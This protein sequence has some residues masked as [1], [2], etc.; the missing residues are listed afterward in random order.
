MNAFISKSYFV[1]WV[2]NGAE[3]CPLL[4]LTDVDLHRGRPHR[5]QLVG[6][7]AAVEAGVGGRDG[8]DGQLM[9]AG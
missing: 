4:K 6:G 3:Q 1:T 9:T 2:K 7:R 5:A 8:R